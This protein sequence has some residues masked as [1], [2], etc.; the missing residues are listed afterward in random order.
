MVRLGHDTMLGVALAMAACVVR[1]VLPGPLQ[2]PILGKTPLPLVE[3]RPV[4]VRGAQLRKS[5]L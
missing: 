4:C 1:Q 5:L 2:R 3:L